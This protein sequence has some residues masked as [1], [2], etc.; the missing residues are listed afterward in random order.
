[1]CDAIVLKIA[2]S[3]HLEGVSAQRN[4]ELRLLHQAGLLPNDTRLGPGW[5]EYDAMQTNGVGL[6]WF[7][8]QL[9]TERFRYLGAYKFRPPGAFRDTYGLVF[10]RDLTATPTACEDS[11][12]ADVQ[13]M[14]EDSSFCNL[15]G[16]TLKRS[17]CNIG[18]L[19]ARED[20]YGIPTHQVILAHEPDRTFGLLQV[21]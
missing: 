8:E 5:Q 6:S 4:D 1:M 15:A 11:L 19:W 7:Q 17:K 21:A 20:R 12:P 2:T 16:M 9:A 14:L 18:L 10:R 13:R 3:R